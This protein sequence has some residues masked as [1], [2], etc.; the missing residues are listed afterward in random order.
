MSQYG[1]N[2]LAQYLRIKRL[3]EKRHLLLT[4]IGQKVR[5]HEGSGTDQQRKGGKMRKGF[6]LP[7]HPPCLL[8]LLGI[9]QQIEHDQIQRNKPSV[10]RDRLHLPSCPKAPA[11]LQG[12]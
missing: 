9:H 11:S 10:S 8:F 5:K 6:E 12:F 7:D 1:V 2:L 3:E 4:H